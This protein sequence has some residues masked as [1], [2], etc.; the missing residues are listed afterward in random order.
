MV[1]QSSKSE[2][3][4]RAGTWNWRGEW[5]FW[6][7]FSTWLLNS[8]DRFKRIF[9]GNHGFYHQKPVVFFSMGF[10]LTEKVI[11]PPSTGGEYLG[12]W[13]SNAPFQHRITQGEEERE[14]KEE[15]FG[16]TGRVF[17]LLPGSWL[18]FPVWLRDGHHSMDFHWMPLVPSCDQGQLRSARVNSPFVGGWHGAVIFSNI[19]KAVSPIFLVSSQP[20]H[21]KDTIFFDRVVVIHSHPCSNWMKAKL[22]VEAPFLLSIV[23]CF[24]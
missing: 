7:G 10:R 24:S 22:T 3:W 9:V 12:N 1:F 4:I 8:V 5:F 23:V 18:F 11:D 15:I 2:S 21:K 6:A 20:Y 16:S 19:L 14:R 17:F 13:G